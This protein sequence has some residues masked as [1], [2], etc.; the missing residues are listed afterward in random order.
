MPYATA[1]QRLEEIMRQ[2][3]FTS[4]QAF[5]KSLGA[6]RRWYRDFLV[7]R[8]NNIPFNFGT[9]YDV[10]KK[11]ELIPAL[12][13]RLNADSTPLFGEGKRHFRKPID[14]SYLRLAYVGDILLAERL[15]KGLSQRG[16]ARTVNLAA[17]I[18]NQCEVYRYV[19]HRNRLEIICKALDLEVEWLAEPIK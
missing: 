14:Y 12:I 8:G 11:L 15:S 3:G 1:E 4:P 10:A 9:V 13:H 18:I 5:S 19:P 6:S 17:S 16:F 7:R 2:R